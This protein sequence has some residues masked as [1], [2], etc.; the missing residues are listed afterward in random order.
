MSLHHIPG[1]FQLG[2]NDPCGTILSPNFTICISKPQNLKVQERYIFN[3][4]SNLLF[5]AIYS[6]VDDA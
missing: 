3:S 4:R 1:F 2:M 6:Y 5:I